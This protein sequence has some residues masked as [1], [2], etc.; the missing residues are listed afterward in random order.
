MKEIHGTV[1]GVEKQNLNHLGDKMTEKGDDLK[2]DY[3]KIAWHLMPMKAVAEIVK[4]LMFGAKKYAPKGWKELIHDRGRV[5]DAL[6]RHVIAH[7]EGEVLDQETGL[8]HLAHA[9]CNIIFLLWFWLQDQKTVSASKV[10][11]VMGD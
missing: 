9:G 10:A 6:M 11:D 8:P 4:V 2:K 7:K 1:L 3:G 5:E